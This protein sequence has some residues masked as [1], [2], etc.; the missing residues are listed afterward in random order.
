MVTCGLLMGLRIGELLGLRWE[1]IDFAAGTMRVERQWGDVRG[2]APGEPSQAYRALKRRREH[3][4]LPLP[5]QVVTALRH[6]RARVR[7]LRLMAGERWH[8][9]DAVFPSQY[10]RPMDSGQVNLEF[11]RGLVAAG[12]RSRSFHQLRHGTATLLAS[13][14]VPVNVTGAV[15]GHMRGSAVTLSTYVHTDQSQIKEAME[16]LSAALEG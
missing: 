13:L 12:L 11:R 5:G 10:G 14:G 4:V 9:Q 8:D 6:Q 7:R 3:A 2:R 15:L 1:D 16:R